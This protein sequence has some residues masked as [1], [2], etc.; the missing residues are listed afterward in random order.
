[1]ND[2][3]ETPI[4]KGN[5]M[6]CWSC[7]RSWNINDWL[8]NWLADLTCSKNKFIWR[9]S[10]DRIEGRVPDTGKRVEWWTHWLGCVVRAWEAEHWN[11]QGNLESD[12]VFMAE[13]DGS[14]FPFQS[15]LR[16]WAGFHVTKSCSWWIAFSFFPSCPARLWEKRFAASVGPWKIP[17]AAWKMLAQKKNYISRFWTGTY[18]LS[19]W[20]TM[21]HANSQQKKLYIPPKIPRNHTQTY[22]FPSSHYHPPLEKLMTRLST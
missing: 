22:I 14:I 19:D 11:S 6:T 18:C 20:C 3:N 16:Q 10:T 21:C 9:H 8:E 13:S 17:S 12:L 2:N 7:S 15:N 1:M 5:L 4:L